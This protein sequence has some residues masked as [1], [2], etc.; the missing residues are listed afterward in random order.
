MKH[1]L[2]TFEKQVAFVPVLEW[3]PASMAPVAMGLFKVNPISS[4]IYRT[5]TAFI[6]E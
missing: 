6:I 2:V 4:V 3:I 5:Q 1:L